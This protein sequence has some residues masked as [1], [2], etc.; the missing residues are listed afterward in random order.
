[1]SAWMAVA[2]AVLVAGLMVVTAVAEE[3]ATEAEPDRVYFF[4]LLQRFFGQNL[5]FTFFARHI[6][7]PIL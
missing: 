3:A 2:L 4:Q 5:F 7:S 1:M 6:A